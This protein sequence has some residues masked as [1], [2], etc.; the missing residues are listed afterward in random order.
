VAG[1]WHADGAIL[2]ESHEYVGAKALLDSGGEEE[3]AADVDD[4]LALGLSIVLARVQDDVCAAL[5]ARR[6]KDAGGVALPS[7]NDRQLQR[8][9]HPNAKVGPMS[10][11]CADGQACLFPQKHDGGTDVFNLQTQSSRMSSLNEDPM[12]E[13]YCKLMRMHRSDA[14]SFTSSQ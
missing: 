4:A 11:E 3:A 5:A 7:G 13:S 8:R 10:E 6:D 1:V 12:R 9:Q 14:L 2:P